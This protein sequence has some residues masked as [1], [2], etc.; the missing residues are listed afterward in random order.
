MR[1]GRGGGE[2][3][4]GWTGSRGEKNYSSKSKKR[5]MDMG[6]DVVSVNQRKANANY[7]RSYFWF[8]GSAEE[9]EWQDLLWRGRTGGGPAP[10]ALLV[11]VVIG[12]LSSRVTWLSREQELDICRRP[13]NPGLRLVRLPSP[14]YLEGGRACGQEKRRRRR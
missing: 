13:S 7:K 9:H 10:A 5:P 8:L 12:V 6:T 11:G 3:R 4:G 1:L 14:F 2:G